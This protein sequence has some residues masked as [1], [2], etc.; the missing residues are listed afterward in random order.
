[1]LPRLVTSGVVVGGEPILYVEPR[2][3][4]TVM[5]FLKDHSGTRCKQLVDLTAVD[6]PSRVKRFEVG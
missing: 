1:M 5:E 3:L 6:V 2:N 4:T